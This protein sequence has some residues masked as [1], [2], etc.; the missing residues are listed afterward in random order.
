MLTQ[1]T[2]SFNQADMFY[3]E[4]DAFLHAAAEGKKIRSNIDEVLMTARMMD[5]LYESARTGREVVYK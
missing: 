4:I 2:T 5:G 1:M 3:D